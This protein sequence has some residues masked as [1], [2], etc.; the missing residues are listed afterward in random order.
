MKRLKALIHVHTDYSFDSNIS[1]EALADFAH[2]E[3]YGCIAV[4]DHDCIAGARRLRS[5]TDLKVIVGEEIST[6]EGHLIGLFLEEFI[7]PG[8]SALDTAM[9]I[10]EQGGLVFLPHPF[11]KAFGCGLG[12]V[13]WRI[14]DW[15]DAVE[16]NNAQNLL[17]GPDRR[18]WQFAQRTGLPMF[19]GADSH[20]RTSIAPCHQVLRDFSGPADFLTALSEAELTV[21]R[22]SLSYFAGVAY[23]IARHTLGMALP[24]GFGRY[25]TAA[26]AP[27]AG[28]EPN[29]GFQSVV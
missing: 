10:R 20:T 17:P 24:E 4:T 1:L 14:V 25:A 26:I 3:G 9:A 19:V 2:A 18:A 6:R 27:R 23:R 8:M 28:I 7:R 15:I 21:G 12:E 13:A 22:H 11:V 16:V 5:M 29:Y